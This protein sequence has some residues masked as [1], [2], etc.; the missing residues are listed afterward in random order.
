MAGLLI[1]FRA[2]KSVLMKNK[3]VTSAKNRMGKS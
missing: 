1:F 3:K 2:E